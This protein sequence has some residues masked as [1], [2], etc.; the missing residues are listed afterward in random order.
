MLIAAGQAAIR[1]TQTE[2]QKMAERV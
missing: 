2:V 1:G